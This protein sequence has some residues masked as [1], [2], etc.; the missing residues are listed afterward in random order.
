[1]RYKALLNSSVVV[2]KAIVPQVHSALDMKNDG[3][4]SFKNVVCDVNPVAIVCNPPVRPNFSFVR[5]CSLE[6]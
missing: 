3:M 6:E 1:M 5:Y 4:R 2:L